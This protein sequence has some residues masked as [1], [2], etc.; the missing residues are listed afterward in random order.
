M[1]KLSDCHSQRSSLSTQGPETEIAQTET[2]EDGVSQWFKGQRWRGRFSS[3]FSLNPS[4]RATRQPTVGF[5]QD[6]PGHEGPGVTGV[7]RVYIPVWRYDDPHLK[8][9]YDELKTLQDSEVRTV[10]RKAAKICHSEA[11]CDNYSLA[12]EKMKTLINEANSKFAAD[13]T[14]RSRSGK[15][16]QNSQIVIELIPHQHLREAE[17]S[18]KSKPKTS[19]Q[20]GPFELKPKKA[21]ELRRSVAELVKAVRKSPS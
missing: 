9:A 1:T 2:A 18:V 14:K 5:S 11:C 6:P 12:E 20:F 13:S 21:A 4:G 19:N 16:S 7:D 3:V 10:L 15:E 17:Y 8:L